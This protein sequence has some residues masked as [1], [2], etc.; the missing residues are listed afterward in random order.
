[1]SSSPTE[2]NSKQWKGVFFLVLQVT[3]WV[4]SHITTAGKEILMWS[5]LGPRKAGWQHREFVAASSPPGSCPQGPT[6]TTFMSWPW[7]EHVFP[8]IFGCWRLPKIDTG[9][10][11]VI[12]ICTRARFIYASKWITFTL[13]LRD[14]LLQHFLLLLKK[15]FEKH[16]SS[17]NCLQGSRH[18][19]L[20]SE[21]NRE[22]VHLTLICFDRT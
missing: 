14:F 22:V 7:K 21:V 13:Q 19:D 15:V 3:F 9:L 20:H 18:N 6:G 4:G 16:A 1:M 10:C 11:L 12:Y 17:F 8:R 5:G 2:A